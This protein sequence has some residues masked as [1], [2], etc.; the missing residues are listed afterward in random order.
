MELIRPVLC[1]GDTPA[2]SVKLHVPQFVFRLGLDIWVDFKP[3]M[4][5]DSFTGVGSI[6]NEQTIMKNIR[7]TTDSEQTEQG[8]VGSC[9][10]PICSNCTN[11]SV[12][13]RGIVSQWD[14]PN[15]RPT[16]Q[17]SLSVWQS[18]TNISM[19][20]SHFLCEISQLGTFPT[21][22]VVCFKTQVTGFND[23]GSK[24]ISPNP[25]TAM[26]NPT[27]CII[28]VILYYISLYIFWISGFQ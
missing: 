2:L 12:T 6:W 11:C 10:N 18:H 22:A 8:R 4:S 5:Y 9:W 14:P 19:F 23:F 13:C 24:K 16:P 21:S 20:K 15:R 7:V 3:I 27:V 25:W 17:P 28:S 26:E 1:T